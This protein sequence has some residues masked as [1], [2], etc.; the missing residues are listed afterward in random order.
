MPYI[1]RAPFK[2]NSEHTLMMY[3]HHKVHVDPMNE[4]ETSQRTIH[5]VTFFTIGIDENFLLDLSKNK[6]LP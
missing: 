2:T 4:G 6:S 5:I 1:I 3:I